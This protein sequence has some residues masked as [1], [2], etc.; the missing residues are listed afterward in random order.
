MQQ[1]LEKKNRVLLEDIRTL[2]E[3]IENA[4]PPAQLQPYRDH[5]YLL[6]QEIERIVLSNLTRLKIIAQVDLLAEIMSDTTVA[7]HWIMHLSAILVPPIHEPA[8]N[9]PISLEVLSWLHSIHSN[10]STSFPAIMHGSWSVLPF[11]EGRLPIYRVPYLERRRLLFQPLLFHEFGHVLYALHRPEMDD[12]V[13]E[14]QENILDLLVPRSRRNDRYDRLQSHFRETIAYTWYKWIQELFCDAVGFTIGGPCF[15]H[16][17]AFYL[18]MLQPTDFCDAP[19]NLANSS[20]P[21]TW[22]RVRF[23]VKRSTEQGFLELG[24]HIDDEWQKIADAI[25]VTEDY[26]GFYDDTLENTVSQ[27]VED[28]LIEADPKHY[29]LEQNE[30]QLSSA[31]SPL[32]LLDEA[33]KVYEQDRESYTEWENV[34]LPRFLTEVTKTPKN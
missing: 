9:Y 20:H 24:R 2:R 17:F 3:S 25:S 8:G 4:I 13:K 16:A 33:W 27:A 10:S 29:T 11:A 1:I 23:L 15:L 30:V 6:C 32:P 21:T 14:M 5:I 26:Y 34:K 31:K 7:T 22:L 28:M 18:S 12:L 19:Q